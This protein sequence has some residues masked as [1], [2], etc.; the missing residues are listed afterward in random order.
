MER[1]ELCSQGKLQL[2]E[3]TWASLRF[4]CCGTIGLRFFVPNAGKMH[5]DTSMVLKGSLLL[6]PPGI[7]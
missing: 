7:P 6:L 4:S 2:W 3:K 5:R 1:L